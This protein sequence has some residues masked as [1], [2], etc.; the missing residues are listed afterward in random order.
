MKILHEFCIRNKLLS[1]EKHLYKDKTPVD[2]M[3]NVFGLLKSNSQNN[4]KDVE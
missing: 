1:G 4:N 3:T 2:V